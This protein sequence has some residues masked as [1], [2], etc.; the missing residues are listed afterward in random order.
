MHALRRREELLQR[1]QSTTAEPAAYRTASY[2]HYRIRQELRSKT[3]FT[4]RQHTELESLVVLG[5]FR[6]LAACGL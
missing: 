2:L 6:E 5:W 3:Y 1:R 4:V